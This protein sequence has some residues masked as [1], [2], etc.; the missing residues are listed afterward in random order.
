MKEGLGGCG[1]DEAGSHEGQKQQRLQEREQSLPL[2]TLDCWKI[3]H[4]RIV[5]M[6]LQLPTREP[7]DPTRQWGEELAENSIKPDSSFERET[8]ELRTLLNLLLLYLVSSAAQGL[9]RMSSVRW[10][11]LPSK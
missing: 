10:S 3:A 7:G 4:L 9:A 1:I 5:C 8:P 2:H 6:L 11:A